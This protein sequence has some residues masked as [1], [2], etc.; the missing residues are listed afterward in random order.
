MTIKTHPTHLTI[1]NFIVNRTVARRL[2][3]T[4]AFHYHALPIATE[5]DHITVAM[6]N[7]NDKIACT[8]IADSLGAQPYVVKGNQST[9]DQQL[10]EIWPDVV[11]HESLKILTYHQDSPISNDVKRYA[12]YVGSMLNGQ[13]A[14]FQLGQTHADF[15]DLVEQASCGQDLVIIGEP[16]QPLIKKI[17]SGPVGCKAA[18][19]VPTSVLVTR[20]P[21]WPLKR[22]LFVTRGYQTDNLAVDWLIRLARPSQALATVLALTPNSSV[23]C[24]RA[25]TTMPRGLADWLESETPLGH[26]LRRISQQLT[27]WEIQGR[28]R[29]RQ[30]TLARQIEQEV[31]EGDYDLV[32]IAAEPN[33][34]WERRLV[35]R[36][37]N[38]LL[39]WINCPV[40][41]AKGSVG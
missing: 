5:N 14:Y 25:S 2:S 26:Q 24:Q 35:G 1:D 41:V 23:M 12:E 19:W 10:A 11:L 7:P 21:R 39:H 36:V 15:K 8:A 32:V 9:I 30:G 38:P 20:R 16:E 18:E 31:A 4:V 37:V 28:L 22:V 40:L 3:P 27:N 13:L 29:F 6:A 17:L 33:D 34:W